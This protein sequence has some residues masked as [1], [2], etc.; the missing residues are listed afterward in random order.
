MLDIYRQAKSELGYV[1]TRFHQ[2]L[3]DRGGVDAAK[4]LLH[5]P[6]S[7]G[8][9]PHRQGSPSNSSDSVP[10]SELSGPH[11]PLT[12]VGSYWRQSAGVH[13]LQGALP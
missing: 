4:Q 13:A 1:A 7:E 11:F 2:M 9:T 10:G 3:E 12:D 5:S 8:F 6:P